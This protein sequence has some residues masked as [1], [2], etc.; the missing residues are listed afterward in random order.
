MG[1]E[2]ENKQ[3]NRIHGRLF[4]NRIIPIPIHLRPKAREDS[5]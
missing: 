4:N 2:R 5:A 3:D 1:I